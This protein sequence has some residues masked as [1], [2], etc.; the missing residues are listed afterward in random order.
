MF[1][2]TASDGVDRGALVPLY[3]RELPA[4]SSLV[5]LNFFAIGLGGLAFACRI[6]AVPPPP[7]N[8]TLSIISK[9]F[10]ALAVS[11][12]VMGVIVSALPRG[13][14]AGVA[15]AGMFLITSAVAGWTAGGHAEGIGLLRKWMLGMVASL[16]VALPMALVVVLV[17]VAVSTAKT[18][19]G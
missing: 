17:G 9:S 12:F 18:K 10:I 1:V 6:C 2:A 14:Q 19:R 4:G 15:I 7:S 3:G 13:I 5:T 8:K 11:F 16:L